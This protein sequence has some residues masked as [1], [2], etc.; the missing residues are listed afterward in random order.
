MAAEFCLRNISLIRTGFLTY[1]NVLGH[2][3]DGFTSC[4][5]EVVLRIFIALK[6]HRPR[7]GL[8]L[9]ISGQMAS[10]EGDS[11][12]RTYIQS[13]EWLCIIPENTWTTRSRGDNVYE[14]QL[15][16]QGDFAPPESEVSSQIYEWRSQETQYFLAQTCGTTGM[17]LKFYYWL[18]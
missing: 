17:W 3:A 18:F 13:L 9:R 1:S 14:H 12:V 7:P 6:I 16:M 11:K 8:N 15:H 2:G 5:Q 4:P 10:T